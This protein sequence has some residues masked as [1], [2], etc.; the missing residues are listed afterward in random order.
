MKGEEILCHIEKFSSVAFA[1]I[2]GL[3]IVF[4]LVK[5]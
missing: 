1:N 4:L 2:R 3:F 5:D